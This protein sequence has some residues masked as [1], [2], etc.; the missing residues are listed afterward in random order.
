MS[1]LNPSAKALPKKVCFVTIGATASFAALICG[2]LSSTFF[3]ALQAH[4]YTDLLVQYGADG[5]QLYTSAVK[6][7]QDTGLYAAITVTGFPVD[8][9][10]LG[11]HMVLA[12]TGGQNGIEGVVISHAG[13]HA[14]DYA[15]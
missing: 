6:Q 11:P 8:Q 9:A 2:V 15:C 12:K 4:D 13:T 1:N 7:V 14:V 5:Q 3:A 10:G